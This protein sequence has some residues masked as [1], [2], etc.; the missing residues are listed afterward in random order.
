MSNENII[1]QNLLIET[2]EEL[3]QSIYEHDSPFGLWI[4]AL[5]DF[6]PQKPH[7]NVPFELTRL[8]FFDVLRILLDKQKVF[9]FPPE[10][11]YINGEL[12][13]K[14]RTLPQYDTPDKPLKNIWLATTE[15]IIGYLHYNWPKGIKNGQ[16]ERLN[17][18]WFGSYCPR[19]GWYD[20]KS[21]SIVAS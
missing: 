12:T 10:E 1:Y 4:N 3:N 13:V 18:F 8:L 2:L 15:E 17:D 9:M 20:H 6:I 16:D 21:Q 14:C 11:Y 7:F 19:I 5:F